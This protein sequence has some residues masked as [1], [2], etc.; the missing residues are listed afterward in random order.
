MGEVYRA[1][2]TKLNRDVAIKVLPESFALDA[3][4]VARFTRE[5]QV[6]ASVNHPNIAA[7]YAVETTS[8]VVSGKTTP[9]VI[10]TALV[11]E[12]V[13]GDDLSVLI[14]RG[15][16]PLADALP[17]A[18]QIADALEAAHEQGIVHRDLKPQNV[19][20]RADGT[21]KVLD[22]GLAKAI[23]P[24]GTSGADAMNSPTLTA[25]ATQ[26]GMIIGTAAYMSPEQAK[27]RAVDKRA[28][29]WA[30][31]AVLYEMCT[32]TRAFKGDD[33]SDTLASVLKD[34]AD[35]GALPA[36]APP[37][38]RALIARCL[39][40]DVKL[41]LRDIGEARVELAKIAD[42]HDDGSSPAM[43][44][45]A[46]AR[47]STLPWVLAAALL[48][49]VLAISALWW[50]ASGAAP[51]TRMAVTLPADVTF[52]LA[53]TPVVAISRDGTR[54]ALVGRFK[55]V[56]S[57]YVRLIN[58]F[59]PRLIAGTE[60][61]SSPFFNPD[62]TWIAFV[63]EGKLKK[64][65][66][67]GGPVITLTDG[68]GDNRGGVWTDRDTIIYS[69]APATPIYQIPAAG[70]T[71][72]PASTIEEA[73][74]ERTHRWPSI[75]PDGQ[76][77][78]VTVGSVEHPD[79]YDDATIEAIRLD[80]GARH[81]VVRSGRAAQYVSS[82][83]LLFLRGKVLYAVDFDV[84][85]AAVRGTPVPVIDG[86]SG[87]VTTGSA[88]YAVSDTGTIVF[89]PGD[90]SGGVRQM[91]WVD[92]QGRAAIIDVP[93]AYYADP[94]VAPDGR[95]VAISVT[96]AGSRRD[97]FVI[98]TVR[99]TTSRL[100]FDALENR[101]P[102]WTHDGR[103]L[104]YVTFDRTRNV[105]T[106]M[107]K[108]ADGSGEAHAITEV[109]GQ[110]YAEDLT[111]DDRTLLVS[112]NPSTAR[113]KFEIFKV[114]LTDGAKPVRLIAAQTTDVANP[115]IS[116]D[117]RWVA[118]YSLESGQAEVYVQP[119]AGS[120]SR[121]QISSSGG[122][123]PHWSTDGR[124]LYY[125]NAD[126]LMAVPIDSGAAFSPGK[127]RVFLSG[128]AIPNTD[129]GQTYHVDPA[130]PRFLMLRVATESAVAPHAR[131]I[132]NWFEELRRLGGGK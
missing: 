101:T 79:D 130:T 48:A 57:L 23:D 10:S 39:E 80:T 8:G 45:V 115:A 47:S 124:T 84:K 46:I 98:D 94:H 6:L 126:N 128:V 68:L 83:H 61:A 38:L 86:I 110:A 123:Q 106:I 42:G 33:V 118:Y 65:S 113:G 20:V 95:R 28:D 122:T 81:V 50:R 97:I 103:R 117:G 36:S 26:M 85:D 76:T 88:H 121:A 5:A 71:P 105:S 75:L 107:T 127:A 78:L 54:I 24:A 66:S 41:R 44:G 19:K 21:V 119:F 1:R 7:I 92:G 120:A 3:D 11:M 59:E 100:T 60:G 112:A 99:G 129:S 131:V 56:P 40:R 62:G 87:D 2:D 72:T 125:Q 49:A 35:L 16:L 13:E 27:G 73:R 63:A 89:V 15:P 17:I 34:T 12:L 102:L 104:V 114:E 32:G 22:F 77:V 91:A 18:R 70:G 82:G 30:F 116:P 4:R 25:R 51:T 14:A 67:A 52:S 90:P 43:P 58:E 9:D 109:G 53:L 132:F 55:G 37:R 108:F 31:G 69:P 93:P 96:G 111:R 29:I 64:V 74:H